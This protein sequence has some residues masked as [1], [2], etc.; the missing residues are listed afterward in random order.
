M[1]EINDWLEAKDKKVL[2]M[3]SMA[4]HLAQL[5][6]MYAP[7]MRTAS[8]PWQGPPIKVSKRYTLAQV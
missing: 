2:L 8:L 3:S 4:C 5:L 1:K 6:T 7:G